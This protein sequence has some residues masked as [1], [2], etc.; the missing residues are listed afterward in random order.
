[1][2]RVGRQKEGIFGGVLQE[3]PLT[4]TKSHLLAIE[5]I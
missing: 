1:M 5:T 2:N 3:L 4:H